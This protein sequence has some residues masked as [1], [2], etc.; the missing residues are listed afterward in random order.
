[1][2]PYAKRTL[3]A[4]TSIS[5]QADNLGDIAIRDTLCRWLAEVGSDVHVLATG[6]PA[7]YVSAFDFGSNVVVHRS[8]LSWLRAYVGAI[9]SGR[10][11]LVFAP[12]PQGLH[13][14]SSEIARSVVNLVLTVMASRSGGAFVIG[15][16]FRGD[17][18]WARRLARL[19]YGRARLVAVRDAQ[20]ARVLGLEDA[21]VYPDL[22]LSRGYGGASRAT[23]RPLVA[24]SLRSDREWPFEMVEAVHLWAKSQGLR[25]TFVTQVRRDEEGHVALSG[26]LPGSDVVSWTGSHAEQMARV[27]S[28]YGRARVVVSDRLHGL[29]FGAREGAVPVALVSPGDT[30][31]LE[32]LSSVYE[33]VAVIGSAEGAAQAL[34]EASKQEDLVREAV[35]RAQLA[36]D[37]LREGLQVRLSAGPQEVRVVG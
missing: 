12:G 34:A 30:K 31:L 18:R 5:A 16:A 25:L 2:S 19:T 29:L 3:S 28:V 20:S 22:A 6:M 36:L 33:E 21:K 1:M 24:V 14:S 10:A 15:R 27:K 7:D 35:E 4:F 17:D 37:Q 26:R 23:Y 13:R 32:T 8:Q 11:A 9:A